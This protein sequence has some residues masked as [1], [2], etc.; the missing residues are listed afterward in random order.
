MFFG[1][2][3]AAISFMGVGAIFE[4]NNIRPDRM[5]QKRI[6]LLKDIPI[7]HVAD[8]L[9]I[10]LKG[11]RAHC[12]NPRHLDRNPSLSFNIPGNFWHCFGCGAGGSN[13]DLVMETLS[14]DCARAISWLE[15]EFLADNSVHSER[16]KKKAEIPNQALLNHAPDPEVYQWLLD[17]TKSGNGLLK[18]LHRRGISERTIKK[19]HVV[20]FRSPPIQIQRAVKVFGRKRVFKS[21]LAQCRGDQIL[22]VWWKSV[23]VF[24]FYDLAGNLCYLQ[25]RQINESAKAKYLGLHSIQKPVYNQ[26]ILSALKKDSR[27][28]LVEGV[29]DALSLTQLG[30][31]ALGFLGCN[32]AL[33]PEFLELLRPFK[34]VIIPDNDPAGQRFL[35]NIESALKSQGIR[36]RVHNIGVRHKDVNDWLVSSKVRSQP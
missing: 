33:A 25:A 30:L 29:I 22:P 12:V 26:Q 21:G 16:L 23:I 32:T 20:A 8:R 3:K 19:S 18:Y 1:D 27:L 24:P 9:K 2:P 14:V 13:I 6:Q 15:E 34:N 5:T 31:N 17:Q 4:G 10:N 36:C 11:T 35:D 7:L 28:F